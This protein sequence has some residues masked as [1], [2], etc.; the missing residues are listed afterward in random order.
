MLFL[1]LVGLFALLGVLT[2]MEMATFSARKERMVQAAESGDQRGTMVNAFQRSPADYLSA[3]QMVAT[4]ANFVIG[5]MIGSL[6]DAPV[7][8]FLERNLPGMPGK[9]QLSWVISI[10]STTI[11][12]LIF[13]NVY[14]K[15]I[16][17]VRANE[18]A[19]KT[20]PLMRFWIKA[21][22][23]VTSLV[24]LSTKFLAK[25]MQIAPDEKFRV[26]ERDIDSLL[27]EGVRAGSLDAR[28]QEIMKRTLAISD[29]KVRDMMS[30]ADNIHWIEPIW[31]NDQI[32]NFVKIHRHSNY[33][34]AEGSIDRCIGVIRVQDWWETQDLKKS[35]SAPVFIDADD[36]I[37][38]AIDLIRPREVRM[39]VVQQQGRT[40]GV[41][42]LND[43]LSHIMGPI[44]QH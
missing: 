16:G 24:R 29:I 26:T 20:A 23:P 14:P 39:L 41:V 5:A 36:C 44:F 30:P 7:S 33:M 38:D 40:V 15:H 32:K 6:I 13:T 43:L 42:T 27:S 19:I 35:M 10:G 8:R 34:V 11:L 1:V 21:T 28:E 37:R 18:I 4:A 25:L 12:A 2:A 9:D 3:I 31:T 22:W 17:F